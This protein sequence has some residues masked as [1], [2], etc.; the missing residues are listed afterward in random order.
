MAAPRSQIR[1]EL[2]NLAAPIIGLN[3]LSVL[4]LVVDTAMCGR[5]PD[6][7]AALTSLGF[8]TQLVFLLLVLMMGLTVGTVALVARAHGAR[9]HV[10]VNHLLTQSTQLTALL[11]VALGAVGFVLAEPMI[12]ALGASAEI[13][14]LGADYLRPL[15]VGNAFFYLMVLYGAV[16][17]GVGNTRLP[18][19][20]ALASN[21]LNIALNYGLILGNWGLPGL[22]VAGAGV[23]TAISHL[24]NVVV[25][26]TLLRRG[27]IKGLTVSLRPERVDRPLVGE[28]LQIGF[29]AAIDMVILNAGFLSI[30]GMLGRIDALAVAAHGVGLRIQA[31]AFVPGL[32]VSQATAAL[33]GQALG[34]GDVERAR[35]I[36]GASIA[37][38]VAIMSTLAAIIVIAAHP[39]V[40]VFDVAAGSPLESYAVEWMRLL[41]YGMPIVG[42]HIA[43]IGLLQGAGATPV[44]LRINAVGTLVFQ[45]PLGAALAFP[46]GL[47]VTGLWLSF[48]LSFAVKAALGYRAYRA[49]RWARTGKSLRSSRG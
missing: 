30:I 9:D 8:A 17:R 13:A 16:C 43:L 3:L 15:M 18:F 6:S 47:G 24:F 19:F 37:L 23:G 7:E 34:A 2:F 48:P 4:T 33:V 39:I 41:G 49:E 5:L 25:M 40:S 28:V 46:L 36:T 35:Q 10:R 45:I 12:R 27:A 21:G 26:V 14:E 42:L 1:G 22:G 38:C 29:P 11:G 20:I 31:L 44:S 32:A